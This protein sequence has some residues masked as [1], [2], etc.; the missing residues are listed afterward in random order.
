M[1]IRSRLRP[2]S[3]PAL[4]PG[5][6][7]LALSL[8]PAAPVVAQGYFPLNLVGGAPGEAIHTDTNLSAGGSW[9]ITASG[10][11]PWWIANAGSGT[12][13]LYDGFGKAIPLVVNIP[14]ATGTGTGSPTGIVFN[15]T[16]DFVV[17]NGTSSGVARFIFAT[18]DGTI[19]GWSPA[20]SFTTAVTASRAGVAFTGLATG[21][22]WCPPRLNPV[23]CNPT[24]N[25]LYAADYGDGDVDVFD[26]N[27]NLVGQFT[28]RSVPAGFAPF[29][30]QNI[31]GKL[32]VTFGAQN[33]GFAPGA[34]YVDVFDT[35][36]N[37]IKHLVVNGP[38]FAP[39]GMALAPKNF[40][41]F[42]NALLVGNLFDGHI[43]AF[44]PS[45]GASLG[46]LAD[47]TG[48]P[49]SIPALWGIAFGND[50]A[51]GRAN[52]L[53]FASGAGVFGVIYPRG[54]P[55]T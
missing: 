30:I 26:T 52:A 42:S 8:L 7:I 23:A 18:L 6:M 48:A 31:N 53:Y 19:A 15:G 16:S 9:G 37:L 39:W 11:S 28:D 36:G 29:G 2:R 27:F 3:V 17:S 51:S 25:F 47:K 24:A 50:H 40:G 49:I 33:F 43:N 4:L 1:A 14:P 45:T 35:S 13:T 34:G 55:L 20:V 41:A 32:Y 10:G 21:Q 46:W 12:S 22:G 38:L 44:D 54:V 5:L